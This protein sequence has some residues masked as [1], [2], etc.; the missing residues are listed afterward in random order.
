[1]KNVLQ[2]LPDISEQWGKKP[3]DT[4]ECPDNN[5]SVLTEL[6]ADRITVF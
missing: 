1:M 2:L 5:I 4:L 6:N 3:Q